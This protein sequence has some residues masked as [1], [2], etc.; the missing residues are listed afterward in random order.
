MLIAT[1]RGTCKEEKNKIEA[2]KLLLKISVF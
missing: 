1:A 2:E